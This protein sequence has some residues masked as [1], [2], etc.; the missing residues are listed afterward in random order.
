MA[1]DI[2]IKGDDDES[3]ALHLGNT[4]PQMCRNAPAAGTCV[5]IRIAMRPSRRWPVT[6]LMPL[7]VADC[8]FCPSA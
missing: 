7:A 3:A 4:G 6:F 8:P 2:A 1:R 5:F